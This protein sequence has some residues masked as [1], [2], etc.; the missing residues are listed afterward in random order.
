VKIEF[1]VPA[2]PVSQPRQRHRIAGSP[3]KQFV[4]NYTPADHPVQNFKASV[5]MAF[6][7]AYQGAPVE[8]SIFMKIEAVFP[9]PA[10]LIWK[11]DKCRGINF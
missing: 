3:G 6:R 7:Q 9:R 2:I 5:R 11:S 4:H 1:S 10:R 8:G